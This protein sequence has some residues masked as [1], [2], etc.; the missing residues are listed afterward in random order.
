MVLRSRTARLFVLVDATVSLRGVHGY[1]E[2]EFLN[3]L[4]L[5]IKSLD[6]I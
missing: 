1:V 3:S 4:K 6:I 5:Q 2:G